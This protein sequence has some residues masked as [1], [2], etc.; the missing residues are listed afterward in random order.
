MMTITPKAVSRILLALWVEVCLIAPA[1]AQAPLV[2]PDPII[3]QFS[4]T[5]AFG[6]YDMPLEIWKNAALK[7][8]T[9]TGELHR[10]GVETAAKPVGNQPICRAHFKPV[11]KYGV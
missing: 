8:R 1:M 7:T 9:V 5:H 6:Q 3:E 4:E 11:T 10:I 2:L